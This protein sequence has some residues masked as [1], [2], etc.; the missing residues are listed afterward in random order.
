MPPHWCGM[1]A[2]ALGSPTWRWCPPRPNP[3]QQPPARLWRVEASGSGQ[4]GLPRLPARLHSGHRAGCPAR[5]RAS[6]K[7]GWSVRHRRGQPKPV[8]RLTPIHTAWSPGR[9]RR[10]DARQQAPEHSSTGPWRG[11]L[12]ALRE[13]EPFPGPPAGLPLGPTLHTPRW[14]PSPPQPAL[15]ARLRPRP[16]RHSP[17]WRAAKWRPT[18][19]PVQSR[20]G[21]WGRGAG[22]VLCA[23]GDWVL[24][25]P[26]HHSF[27]ICCLRSQHP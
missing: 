12:P 27:K 4:P 13:A 19:L 10:R 18:S 15:P 1:L 24:P 3:G 23:R 26:T 8:R 21:R 17:D 11:V 5:A 25:P 7:P 20:R 9:A 14:D 6:M 16:T 2:A 22:S